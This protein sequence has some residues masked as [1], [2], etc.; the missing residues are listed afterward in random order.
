RAFETAGFLDRPHK[1]SAGILVNGEPRGTVEVVY[2]EPRPVL[3][4]GPFLKEE[5]HLLDAIAETLGV[6]ISHQEAQLAL[7]ERVKEL[8]CLH[9]IAKIAQRPGA[10][11]E[12]ILAEVVDLLPPGLLYP[13]IAA[14]R[15]TLEGKNYSTPGFVERP[16]RLGADI[17]ADGKRRGRVEVV[18]R[19]PMPEI[20][21]GPFLK[22]ER[23]LLNEV[24][25]QVGLI[26]ERSEAE[27]ERDRLQQQLRHADRLA[28]IGQLAAGA[29]HELNEPLGNILGFA[30]LAG[31]LPRLPKQA[32]SDL[33][34]IVEAALHAREIIKKLMIFSRQM[35]TQMEPLDLN[36]VVA[37]GILFLESRLEQE[38]VRLIRDLHE[39][40]PRIRGDASQLQQ[41]LVNLVVNA[42]QSMPGGGALTIRTGQDEAEVF[43]IVE[44][45][46]VG[47]SE[48][49]LKQIFLPFF[50]TKQVG[51]GTGLGLSVVHGIVT[52]HNGTISVA[53]REGRGSR[54][55]IRFPDARL[56]PQA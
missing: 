21:E 20:D 15:I 36:E 35:P 11:I 44:D 10:S 54:F 40:L 46:G 8:T 13:E 4:E 7:R 51:Q 43:L 38:S 30:E 52:S 47:M 55:E 39:S 31:K 12:E 45:T 22:E 14:A 27:N 33:K 56:Q 1:Q 9:G 32:H 5:R 28:T 48:D 37:K 23:S 16:D 24:A 53:S 29:A 3:D 17:T 41:V 49:V 6:T 25:R 34:K 2:A 50:T 18:Y 42:L 26:V 19:H